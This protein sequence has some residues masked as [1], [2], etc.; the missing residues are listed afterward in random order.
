MS[1]RPVRAVCAVCA[2]DGHGKCNISLK[3]LEKL[4]AALECKPED[5]INGGEIQPMVNKEP[6]I[7]PLLLAA[8]QRLTPN[9][10][11]QLVQ[12]ALILTGGLD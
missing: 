11:K 5:L 4:A 1:V 3:N 9:G 8:W 6:E 7:D 12:I 2:S 10:R